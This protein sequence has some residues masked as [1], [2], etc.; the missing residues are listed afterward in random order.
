MLTDFFAADDSEATARGTGFV[1]RISKMTGKFFLAL[2]TFGAW[3]EA[4]M[5]LARLAAKAA[6]SCQPVDVSP[7]AIHQRMNTNAMAFLQ[8]MLCQTL[9]THS[10]PLTVC[11]MIAWLP[12]LPK[13]I[14]LAAVGL[15]FPKNSIRRFLAL[16]GVQQK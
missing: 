9:A 15:N 5:T 7:E 2:A 16:E 3:S 10:M 11:V 12:P 1:Q 14:E 8:D 4:K 13:A 6:Q